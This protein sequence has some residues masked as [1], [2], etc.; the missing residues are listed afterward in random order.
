MY[1]IHFVY[2]D[3]QTLDVN[4]NAQE[5][6]KFMDSIGNN[7]VYMNDEKGVGIWLPIDKVRY[8]QINNM[9]EK[10]DEHRVS[11]VQSDQ[12]GDSPGICGFEPE[13]GGS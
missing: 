1:K 5:V 3:N 2:M 9:D 13:E 8:F 4:V 11:E 6:E 7:R 12:Q 10:A